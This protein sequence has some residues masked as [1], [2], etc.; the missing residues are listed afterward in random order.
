MVE[1]FSTFE[2]LKPREDLGHPSV[3]IGGREL[4]VDRHFRASEAKDP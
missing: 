2:T 4:R 3:G 1:W